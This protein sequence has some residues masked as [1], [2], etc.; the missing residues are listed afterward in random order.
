M[1]HRNKMK[2]GLITPLT[3]LQHRYLRNPAQRGMQETKAG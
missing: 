1:L 3:A 2:R